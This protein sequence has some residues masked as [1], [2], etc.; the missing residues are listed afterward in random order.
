[1]GRHRR[2]GPLQIEHISNTSIPGLGGRNVVDIAIVAELEQHGR[3]TEQLRN[4]GFQ[5]APFKHY[6][7]VLVG[8]LSWKRTAYPLMVYL[9]APSSPILAKWL[10]FRAYMQGHPAEVQCY[11]AAKQS[12]LA[13][14]LD[15]G[16]D[17]Q[18]AKNPILQA[19]HER[20]AHETEVKFS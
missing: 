2:A 20:L 4:A 17:Y 14:G 18:T 8:Q 9:A 6:L 10:R 11:A 19:L 1:M 7:P 5:P 16:D 13:Q 3:I 15:R 12:S